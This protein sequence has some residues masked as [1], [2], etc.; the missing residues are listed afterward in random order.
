MPFTP[1]DLGRV[2]QIL[3][4]MRAQLNDLQELATGA[5]EKLFVAVLHELR[6]ALDRLERRLE[7]KSKA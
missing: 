4:T 6:G 2:R 5:D 7:P 3:M 1:P